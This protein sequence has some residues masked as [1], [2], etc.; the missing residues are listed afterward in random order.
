MF[1]LPPKIDA[2][3]AL[4]T[5]GDG[6]MCLLAEC[7]TPPKYAVSLMRHAQVVRQQRMYGEASARVLAENWRQS[8]GDQTDPFW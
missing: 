7:H 3:E 5:L 2:T 4:W 6:T 1:N 8:E